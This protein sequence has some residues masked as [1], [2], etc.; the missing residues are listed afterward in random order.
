[1]GVAA[2]LIGFI[3]KNGGYIPNVEQTEA[4]LFS[5]EFCFLWLPIIICVGI[6]GAIYF[7]RLDGIRDEMT[8]TLELRRKQLEYTKNN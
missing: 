4:A 7:Y 1:M 6:I 3:I 5:I 2:L 8:K